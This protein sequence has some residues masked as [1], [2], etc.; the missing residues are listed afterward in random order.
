MASQKNL[1]RIAVGSKKFYVLW[2]TPI[3]KYESS[4]CPSKKRVAE[5]M[6]YAGA[7]KSVGLSKTKSP[8]NVIYAHELAD[9][10][11]RLPVSEGV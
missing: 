7:V 11:I 9:G 6:R 10:T 4:D 2:V 3:E 5:L 8:K 1:K